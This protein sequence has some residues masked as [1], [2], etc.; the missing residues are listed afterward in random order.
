MSECTHEN[1]KVEFDEEAAKGMDEYQ[2]RER[3][4][5]FFGNCPD[6]GVMLIKY[7]STAHFIYGDW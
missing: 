3:W 6:C 2:V 4:P 1:V 7:A 5:R